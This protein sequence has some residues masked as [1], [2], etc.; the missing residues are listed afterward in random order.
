METINFCQQDSSCGNFK[1]PWKNGFCHLFHILPEK[2]VEV[3]V[4][5]SSRRDV[6]GLDCIFNDIWVLKGFYFSFLTNL[7][8]SWTYKYQ[9]CF[10]PHLPLSSCLLLQAQVI[11]QAIGQAFGVAYQQFLQ[12]NGIKAS[13]LKPGEYSNYLDSQELYNGDLAH[14]S[15]S[16]NLREVSEIIKSLWPDLIYIDPFNNFYTFHVF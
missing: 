1:T 4:S 11:A 13:D 9:T 5:F 8:S 14:F 10:G 15:D 6:F 7:P 2:F 12:T 3:F 16:Q